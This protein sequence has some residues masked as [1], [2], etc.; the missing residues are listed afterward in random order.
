MMSSPSVAISQI[1]K[2]IRSAQCVTVLAHYHPD[3]DAYGSSCGAALALRELGKEVWLLNE[4]GQNDRYRIVPG[5][6]T[7][8]SDW[9]TEE[10]FYHPVTSL[11]LVCDCGD[12]R[13]V[14]DRLLPGIE[15]FPLVANLD[16]HKSNT[17]FGTI[18][19]V[20]PAASSTAEMV[21]DL[22]D[23]L[24]HSISLPVATALYGG[25]LGDTG[26]FRYSSTSA[27]TFQIAERLVRTGVSPALVAEE[28]FSRVSRV[29]VALQADTMLQA[30]YLEGGKV[31]RSTVTGEMFK[32]HGATSEDTD[33]IVERLRDID[34]VLLSALIREHE[35]MWRVS[36]R[37]KDPN[38]DVDL[39]ARAFGGGGHKA[40]AAFRFRRSYAELLAG[41]DPALESAVR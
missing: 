19:V 16:H 18:N 2:A 41:L 38:I 8:Q 27:K 36:L 3:V 34:G 31:V 21:V 11:C 29:A 24:G 6:N 5:L 15:R 17:C 35:D 22:L 32:K 26:S 20:N 39:I 9:P 10:R 40:A 37:S 30:H 28:L 25:I 33:A 7:V 13:R 1:S 12:M 14:G 23:D 4:S